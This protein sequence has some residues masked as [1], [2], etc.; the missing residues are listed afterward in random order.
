MARYGYGQA[1]SRLVGNPAGAGGGGLMPILPADAP[2]IAVMPGHRSV[3]ISLTET[4]LNGG[5]VQDH[6]LYSSYPWQTPAH[7]G[8][9]SG[10]GPWVITGLSNG[11]TYRFQVST[12]TQYGESALSASVTVTPQAVLTMDSTVITA[13]AQEF[14]EPN[15][16]ASL[17]AIRY[18]EWV[19]GMIAALEAFLPEVPDALTITGT[20]SP[21][22]WGVP[23]PG[24]ALGVAGG[25][26][27]FVFSGLPGGMTSSVVGSTILPVGTPA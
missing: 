25:T 3:T 27:P 12:V 22:T 19:N 15:A 4:G 1:Y 13:D 10:A 11:V 2:L 24:G 20:A 18:F 7:S 6:Q 26:A 23:Y 9:L 17:T 5:T 14:Y 21:A 8:V 16:G